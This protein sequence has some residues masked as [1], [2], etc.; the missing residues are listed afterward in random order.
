VDTPA[1]AAVHEQ[2]S[3]V[4]TQRG[5]RVGVRHSAGL[6]LPQH[7]LEHC[8]AL[9]IDDRPQSTGRPRHAGFSHRNFS[10]GVFSDALD[11]RV[12][13]RPLSLDDVRLGLADECARTLVAG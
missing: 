11:F 7:V 13:E 5:V 6:P 12:L 10:G 2:H 1:A 3:Q 8:C 9:A 4:Q